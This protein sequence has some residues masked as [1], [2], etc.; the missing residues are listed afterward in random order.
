MLTDIQKEL[1]WGCRKREEW[2]PQQIF[3]TYKDPSLAQALRWCYKDTLD[4]LCAFTE[5]KPPAICSPPVEGH[6]E[7]FNFLYNNMTNIKCIIQG[8]TW[9]CAL[10]ILDNHN[11]QEMLL[12]GLP[13]EDW[14]FPGSPYCLKT[15]KFS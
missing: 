4:T 12:L 10:F 8:E 15:H 13:A 1:L 9:P 7:S 2:D 5:F 14:Q 3:L 6:P 11:K